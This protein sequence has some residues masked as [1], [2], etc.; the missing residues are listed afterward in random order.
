MKNILLL[1]ESRPQLD[2]YMLML[3][4]VI[5]NLFIDCYISKGITSQRQEGGL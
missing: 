1:Q 2:S 4:N 3:S 5:N